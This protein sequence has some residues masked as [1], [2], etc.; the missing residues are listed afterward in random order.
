MRTSAMPRIAVALAALI[1]GVAPVQGQNQTQPDK[2]VDEAVQRRA[3]EIVKQRLAEQ[4][5]ARR[6]GYEE[7]ERKKLL[8]NEA[9][10][11][12]MRAQAEEVRA[13]DV[14]VVISRYQNDKKVSSLPYSLIVNASRQAKPPTTVLRMG[15]QVPIPVSPGGP[16]N[17]R[18]VGTQI[19]CSAKIR[20]DGQ[21]ELTVSVDDS[22]PAKSGEAGFDQ[23]GIPVIRTFQARNT[24]VMRDGQT[25]QFTIAS[26]RITGEVVRV[27]I[28]VKAAK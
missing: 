1:L 8:E 27:D 7:L 4:E 14:E 25:R 26:D 23:I 6:L 9:I 18:D 21:Y 16:V 13:L 11:R 2:A 22:A 3:D 19:D 28:T 10:D 12:K 17:Y 24:L 20:Q 5:A 15:G